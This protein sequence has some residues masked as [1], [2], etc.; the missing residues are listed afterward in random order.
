MKRSIKIV[1]TVKP[2]RN[3]HVAA[4][5]LRSG[6][7]AHGKTRKAERRLD[8]VALK[9]M[10]GSFPS[11]QAAVAEGTRVLNGQDREEEICAE[12]RFR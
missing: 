8:K 4:A 10:A 12:A 9:R 2:P 1:L 6:A 11:G 7:G 3:G 5:K